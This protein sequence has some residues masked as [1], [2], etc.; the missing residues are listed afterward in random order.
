MWL[1]V[2]FE[3]VVRCGSVSQADLARFPASVRIFDRDGHLVREAVGAEGMRAQWRA[4][5]DISPLLVSATLAVEDARFHDHD[6][7]DG[8]GV[9]RAMVENLRAGRVVSGASTITMQL[10]RLLT[11]SDKTLPGKIGEMIRARHI[12]RALS[13]Q[14]ILE[15]YLNRA[16]YGAGAIGV[17]A[18][19]RRYFGKPSTHLSL[20]EA[21][22]IA[23]LP[24]APTRLNPLRYPDR[25]RA[26]QRKVLSRMRAT[27]AITRA[28]HDRA[29]GEA[30]IYR[31]A[32]PP[33]DA[34]HF[35]DHV[36]AHHAPRDGR[37]RDI[38]TTLDRALQSRVQDAVAHHVRSLATA[39]LGNAAVV[40]LDNDACQVRALVGSAEHLAAPL[41]GV[42]ATLA[43]VSPLRN[44][45]FVSVL[46][47]VRSSET[48]PYLAH[49]CD[50]VLLGLLCGRSSPLSHESEE[51]S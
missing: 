45:P 16:P 23:G 8:I 13:K 46:L 37:S 2:G 15:Q 11:P 42:Y 17:E 28:E 32:P 30:L 4:L 31:G 39:G 43:P 44:V 40:V 29:A 41:G 3:L 9:A 10:A 47:D 6:G 21:A 38:H 49:L 7:I 25:A 1:I 50:G 34:M 19:S 35:T 20:A 5:D 33:L 24:K 14:A 26:R 48:T 27:G 12:E 36:L 18:A 51:E 22:L